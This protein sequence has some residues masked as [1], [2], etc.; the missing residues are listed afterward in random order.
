MPLTGYP[1]VPMG[2]LGNPWAVVDTVGAVQGLTGLRVVGA[3][4]AEVPSVATNLVTIMVAEHIY[5]R[6]HAD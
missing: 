3:S 6:I 2:A 5:Q 1:R 4:I